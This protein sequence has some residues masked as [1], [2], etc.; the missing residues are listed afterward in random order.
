MIPMAVIRMAT[1]P[2]GTPHRNC[3]S[4]AIS[5]KAASPEKNVIEPPRSSRSRLPL[6]SSG[7]CSRFASRQASRPDATSDAHE[8][9]VGTAE[10]APDSVAGEG[11]GSDPERSATGGWTGSSAD[12]VVSE[13]TDRAS[14]S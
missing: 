14:F 8:R 7:L 13:D 11:L 12:G 9:R 6:G 3:A 10:V 2:R 1:M 4:V 5:E